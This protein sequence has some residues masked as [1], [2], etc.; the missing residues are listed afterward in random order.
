MD[1]RLAHGEGG[2]R[3]RCSTQ[4]TAAIAR[5][6]SS[7]VLPNVTP[8]SHERETT[9][10]K[11]EVRHLALACR[12][13]QETSGCVTLSAAKASAV[14]RTLGARTYLSAR[15]FSSKMQRC[16]AWDP[17]DNGAR[18]CWNHLRLAREP[19][20][21][22]TSAGCPALKKEVHGGGSSRTGR[23]WDCR[24]TKARFRPRCPRGQAVMAC[25][26]QAARSSLG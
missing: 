8:G 26:T 14:T 9:S 25:M 23:G 5:A 24:E 6:G 17:P 4:H 22:K 2:G 19:Q 13:S 20:H 12:P 15:R 21:D 16:V 1:S 10:R 18:L 11:N 7:D 3:R